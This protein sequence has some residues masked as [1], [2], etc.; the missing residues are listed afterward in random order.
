MYDVGFVCDGLTLARLCSFG[1]CFGEEGDHF[2]DSLSL[3]VTIGSEVSRRTERYWIRIT[4]ASKD[5]NVYYFHLFLIFALSVLVFVRLVITIS[6]SI[7]L[8]ASE[9]SRVKLLPPLRIDRSLSFL[10]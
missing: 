10:N 9:L 5:C 7:V 1:E 2:F 3:E 6:L 8:L 4:A